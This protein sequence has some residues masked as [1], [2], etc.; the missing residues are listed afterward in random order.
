VSQAPPVTTCEKVFRQVRG[1]SVGPR[2]SE[3]ILLAFFA[4]ASVASLFF[5][6]AS[7]ELFLVLSIN[8]LVGAVVWTLG[9]AQSKGPSA[10]LATVRDWLPA[11]LIL[12]AYRESGLFLTPDPT[13]HLDCLFIKWDRVVLSDPVVLRMLSAC[14]PWLQRY[15]EFAYLL[16]YP[17]V[18]L[19]A[20]V[21]LLAR[22][23][24][25]FTVFQD[26]TTSTR[27]APRHH[28]ALD[29]F[30]T[31]VLLAA[32][33]CYIL[34]PFFPLTPPRELFHDV[35]GPAVE[36]LL[37]RWNL[38]VLDKFS[39]HACIFPSGHV[40]ATTAV[41]LVI[42]KYIPRLGVVFVIAA[43]SI[44]ISTVYGRYHYAADAVAGGLV[45]LAAYWVSDRIL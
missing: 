37:R 13:H 14:S 15:L 45:G 22:R 16:C 8:I 6:L 34:F 24:A 40:A 5:P 32:L 1:I 25:A 11:V 9:R 36:P 3:M 7:R 44:A 29:R 33:T 38:W 19:G 41:A 42:C 28:S 21:L 18:P 4:Y 10:V 17:L 20:G 43:A 39:V 30:W 23:N 31:A 2:L 35:P 12:L 26:R 27:T